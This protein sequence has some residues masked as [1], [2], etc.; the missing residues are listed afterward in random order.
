MVTVRFK[1]GL[2]N[3]MF[4]YALYR[5]L[6]LKGLEVCADL[7]DYQNGYFRNFELESFNNI[8]LNNEDEII[9]KK[10]NNICFKLNKKIRNILGM[11]PIE[12]RYD[13]LSYNDRVFDVKKGYVDGYWQSYKYFL[14]NREDLLNRFEFTSNDNNNLYKKYDKLLNSNNVVSV[15]IRRGDYLEKA[16]AELFGDICTE[17]YYESAIRKMREKVPGCQFLIFSNDVKW[18]LDNFTDDDMT[19]VEGDDCNSA[20]TE[21]QMMS[22]CKHNIIANSSFSW[23][24]AWLNC[25]ENKYIIMP[26]HWINNEDVKDD[27][28]PKEWIRI[29][30]EGKVWE[31]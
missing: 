25:N 2:G 30:K 17:K 4:Q 1:G 12:L 19:V 13:G 27:M 6:E 15:H 23:W 7:S 18:C 3:Q 24:G 8:I 21:L 10:R 31:H 20:M 14:D 26:K 22:Q 11:R 9:K 16:N 28:G 5:T 29:D